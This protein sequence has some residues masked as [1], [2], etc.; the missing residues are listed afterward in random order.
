MSFKNIQLL[1]IPNFWLVVLTNT[2]KTIYKSRFL[3]LERDFANYR[4]WNFISNKSIITYAE[5]FLLA[6]LHRC[7]RN[8]LPSTGLT[9]GVLWLK[10][11]WWMSLRRRW[12]P[13][14]SRFLFFFLCL[15]YSQL[16]PPCF[17]FYSSL[18]WQS[19]SQWTL[20][21]QRS[22]PRSRR[23]WVSPHSSLVLL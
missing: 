15:S 18:S 10:Q 6:D 14:I 21:Q 1:N 8:Q 17:T 12:D 16:F 9:T 2:N 13:V 4:D 5:L 23:P 19:L 7:Q 22:M 3:D 20:R 11:A